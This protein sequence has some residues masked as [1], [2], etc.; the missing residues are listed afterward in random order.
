MVQLIRFVVILTFIS[1]SILAMPNYVIFEKNV[2]GAENFSH[3][4]PI[5]NTSQEL[6]GFIFTD[7]I[8]NQVR[9]F[10]IKGDSTR[11]IDFESTPQKTVHYYDQDN[12]LVLYTLVNKPMV[13]IGFIPQIIEI[14]TF[15]QNTKYKNVLSLQP[16]QNRARATA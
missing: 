7:S 14:F 4:D 13:G 9:L 6:N 2:D 16:K 11:I 5:L 15:S 10:Y 1:S 8:K 3:I 12:T